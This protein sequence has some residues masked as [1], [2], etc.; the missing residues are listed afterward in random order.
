MKGETMHS[1]I[2]ISGTKTWA[3]VTGGERDLAK[4]S[5]RTHEPIKPAEGKNP[6]HVDVPASKI[7]RLKNNE[8]IE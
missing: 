2:K 8:N 4:L 1:K 5:R 7:R 6:A 3:K